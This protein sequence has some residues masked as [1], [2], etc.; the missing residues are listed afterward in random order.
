MHS[1]SYFDVE[2]NILDR[3]KF[4]AQIYRADVGPSTVA[5]PDLNMH[6]LFA[7]SLCNLG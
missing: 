3:C 1:V 4:Y 2:A 7:N 6:D 5:S